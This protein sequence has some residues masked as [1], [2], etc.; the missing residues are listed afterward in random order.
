MAVNK[1]EVNGAAALDL[2]GDT[3][4]AAMLKKG[5]TAHDK[6]GAQI[7]GTLDVPASVA[8]ATPTISVSSSGLITASATQ[9]AGVVSAGTKSATKQL[10]TQGAKTVTPSTSNQT[11]VASGRYTTGAVTVKG[12]A[13]LKAENIKKGTSIFGVTGTLD[14]GGSSGGG[15]RET[16]VFNNSPEPWTG[17]GAIDVYISFINDGTEM[18]RI[19]ISAGATVIVYVSIDGEAVRAHY[20]PNTGADIWLK[21]SYRKITFL[22]PPTGDLLAYLQANAVKQPSDVAVQTD[23]ALTITSNGT[24]NIT[25]DIPYDA[26]SKVAVTVNVSGGSAGHSVTFPNSIT[27]DSP[28]YVMGLVRSDGTVLNVDSY[29]VV[30]GK[31]FQNILAIAYRPETAYFAMRLTLSKG[32]VITEILSPEDTDTSVTTAPNT[33]SAYATNPSMHFYP[34]TDIVISTIS[35]Q[36]MD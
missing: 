24:T 25:P 23:K 34:M 22:E 29:T 4:T 21:Q 2:T 13:N 7:T 26:M 5:I 36:N 12:D 18:N 28:Y 33:T 17:S 6:S 32:S 30:A 15:S 10:T 3:V 14:S 16:W 11:A 9:S 27:Q 8:Q 35:V 31:T 1:V 19:F 20:N